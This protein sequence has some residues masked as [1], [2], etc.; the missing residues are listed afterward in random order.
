[1]KREKWQW[2]F[3]NACTQ[4]TTNGF[5]RHEILCVY[6]MAENGQKIADH[7]KMHYKM[8]SEKKI[9]KNRNNS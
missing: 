4:I 2:I 1:M 7:G 6:L 5:I 8:H 3:M 9:T